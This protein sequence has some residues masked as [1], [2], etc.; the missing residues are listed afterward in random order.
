LFLDE[1]TASLDEPGERMVYQ[2][3]REELP[4]ASIVS[5]GHRSTLKALHSRSIDMEQDLA[6][7]PAASDKRQAP[8]PRA[9]AMP[10]ELASPPVL[11]A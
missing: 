9:R 4:S 10:C 8:F 3:L 7:R 6:R 2:L 11:V 1:A 5:I